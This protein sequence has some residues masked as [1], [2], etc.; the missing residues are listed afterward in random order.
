MA[1]GIRSHKTLGEMIV[2]SHNKSRVPMGRL[3]WKEIPRGALLG[4]Y[5][6]VFRHASVSFQIFGGRQDFDLSGDLHSCNIEIRATDSYVA[7]YLFQRKSRNTQRQPILS[8]VGAFMTRYFKQQSF[9]ALRSR[10]R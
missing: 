3:S 4:H 1:M 6:R 10:K 5:V 9:P 7:D 8:L 2:L